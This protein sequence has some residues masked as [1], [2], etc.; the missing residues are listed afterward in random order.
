MEISG[1]NA[2]DKGGDNGGA[3]GGFIGEVNA[4]ASSSF[5]SRANDGVERGV[6]AAFGAHYWYLV[7]ASRALIADSIQVIDRHQLFVFSPTAGG[8]G[9]DCF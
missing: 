3:K 1:A 9:G 6:E 7:L 2:G 4:G 5:S 8:M